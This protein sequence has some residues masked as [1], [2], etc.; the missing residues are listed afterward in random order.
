MHGAMKKK[1]LN[2]LPV[3]GLVPCDWGV[4]WSLRVGKR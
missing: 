4:G 1:N 2:T 3:L